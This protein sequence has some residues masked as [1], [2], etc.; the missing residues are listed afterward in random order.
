MKKVAFIFDDGPH[1]EQRL[2]MLEV[3]ER[4]QIRVTFA[5]V[6][7]NMEP[8]MALVKA[9]A[10]AGHE[11]I[12]HSW[13][14]AHCNALG[15]SELESELTRTRDL[16]EKGTGRPSPWFWAPYGECDDA[17]NAVVESLGMK[18]VSRLSLPRVSTHDWDVNRDAD[19]IYK[20]ATTDVPDGALTIFHEWRVETLDVLPAIVAELIAQGFEFVT[21]SELVANFQ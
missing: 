5:C 14:H 19:T 11:Q 10:V 12:N 7:K 17:C 4:L 15:R 8:R 1:E 13:S 9:A 21:V 18:A 20:A 3:L 16:L 2:K 6:G